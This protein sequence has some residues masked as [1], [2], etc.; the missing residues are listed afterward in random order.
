MAPHKLVLLLAAL[1]V[2]SYS[3]A[4]TGAADAARPPGGP[5]WPPPPTT[6]RRSRSLL[7]QPAGPGPGVSKPNGAY[8]N[9]GT[10]SVQDIW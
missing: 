7:A 10:F 4:P 2:A 3:A 1:T 5:P 6:L 8:Y 9:M